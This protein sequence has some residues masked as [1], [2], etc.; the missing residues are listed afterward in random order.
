MRTFTMT[1]RMHAQ[2]RALVCTLAGRSQPGASQMKP[3]MQ[4]CVIPRSSSLGPSRLST[5]AKLDGSVLDQHGC[6]SIRSTSGICAEGLLC[7]GLRVA[8]EM[9]TARR[10]QHDAGLVQP[11]VVHLNSS[12][13][14]EPLVFRSALVHAALARQVRA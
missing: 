3:G 8:A 2:Q 14:I 7:R 4:A 1:K 9:V 6:I 5:I 10:E 11:R 12:W 13:L